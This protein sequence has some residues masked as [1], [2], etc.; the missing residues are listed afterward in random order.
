MR[1][2]TRAASGQIPAMFIM[3]LMMLEVPNLIGL[4]LPLGFYVA[5]LIA[6]GR[7]YAENEMTVFFACGYDPAKLIR[8]SLKIACVISLVVLMIM[9]WASPKIA[10]ERAKLL[11]TSGI[12]TLIQTIIPGS[13]REI[14]RAQQVYYVESMNTSHTIA[15]NIFLA[16]HKDNKWEVFWADKAYLQTENTSREDYVVFEQGKAYKGNPGNRD[17]E[18][19]EFKKYQ[20]RIPQPNILLKEDIRTVKTSSLLPL[21]N[22][23]KKK[24]AELQWRFSI[25][26]MV[27]VLTL[28]AIGLGKVNP[29]T[30]KFAKL[31]PAIVLYIIYANAMFVMRDWLMAGKIPSW[32]GLW[33]LHILFGAIGVFLIWRNHF[34]VSCA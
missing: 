6:Y 7:M 1:Y 25:P 13:F 23:D 4:L 3:K 8:D 18:L 31:L 15:G 19:A 12:K 27:I 9:L 22:P 20:M 33:F 24:V 29:R 10:V 32:L 16:R 2:L 28:I 5:L 26:L 17:F 14:S 34:R 11:R 21:N 30:G